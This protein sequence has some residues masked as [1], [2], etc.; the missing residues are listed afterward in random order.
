MENSTLFTLLLLPGTASSRNHKEIKIL[1]LEILLKDV[2][3]V[4]HQV[5]RFFYSE[6]FNY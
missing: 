4:T 6:I 5:T 1:P 3:T 2:I